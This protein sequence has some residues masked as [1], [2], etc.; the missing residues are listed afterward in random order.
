MCVAIRS[1]NGGEFFNSKLHG[2][3]HIKGIAHRLTV[4]YNSHQNRVAER[5]DRAV[6]D[7]AGKL[8]I[9]SGTPECFWSEAIKTA[10]FVID[11]LPSRSINHLTPFTKLYVI[12]PYLT[13]RHPF[14]CLYYSYISTEKT[15]TTF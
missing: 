14:G 7:K 8:L 10:E 12:A 9:E 4:P 13:V 1:D 11:R 5:M 2:Y 3:L 15:P 6:E